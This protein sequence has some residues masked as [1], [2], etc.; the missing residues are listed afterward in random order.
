M[1]IEAGA[2]VLADRGVC[3]I[4]EF[5]KMAS[6]GGGGKG[7]GSRGKGGG[8]DPHALLEGT[9][10]PCRLKCG[11]LHLTF[12]VLYKL[13]LLQQWNSRVYLWQRVV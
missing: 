6:G 5:D 12:T 13:L 1:S 2:L 9:V 8:C 10:M 3:C 11:R 7:Y 4:D